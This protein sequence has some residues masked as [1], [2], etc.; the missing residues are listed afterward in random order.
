VV[1]STYA[2]RMMFSGVRLE[3]LT[4]HWSRLSS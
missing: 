1:A 3:A 2:E 4:A